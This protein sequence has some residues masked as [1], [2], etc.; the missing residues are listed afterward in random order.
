[1]GDA[2]LSGAEDYG[3]VYY[4]GALEGY[5]WG[6]QVVGWAFFAADLPCSSFRGGICSGRTSWMYRDTETVIAE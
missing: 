3:L 6:D 4:Y 5:A 2:D 1:M